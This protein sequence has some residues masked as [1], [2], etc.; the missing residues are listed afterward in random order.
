MLKD[1]ASDGSGKGTHNL[2]NIDPEL[3]KTLARLKLQMLSYVTMNLMC[4]HA[5][6][7]SEEEE[8]VADV[9]DIFRTQSEA[10][11]SATQQATAFLQHIRRAALYRDDPAVHDSIEEERVYLRGKAFQWNNA[12]YHL[13]LEAGRN[14][15]SRE[16][17][18][19]LLLR[20]CKQTFEIMLSTSTS[21]E[22][23]VFDKF[24]E[25][26]QHMVSSCRVVLETDQ[27]LRAMSGL[28]AQF[29]MGL[30]MTVLYGDK[31]PGL[32]DT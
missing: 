16:Y 19:A 30:I 11:S 1:Y 26:F 31:V 20:T 6:I 23:T 3:G 32:L 21:K 2:A 27:E 13:F 24:A 25:Q 5:F 18:G 28:R 29:G 22:E 7:D 17:L 14:V 9:L 15:P 10:V 4:D 8:E 12:F